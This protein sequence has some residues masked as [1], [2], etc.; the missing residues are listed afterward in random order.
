MDGVL[1]VLLVDINE[2]HLNVHVLLEQ[3]LKKKKE[4][5]WYISTEFEKVQCQ[6]IIYQ[7]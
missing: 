7:K 5:K 2:R 1:I 3:K 4:N 6:P